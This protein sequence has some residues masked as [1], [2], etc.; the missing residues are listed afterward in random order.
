MSGSDSPLASKPHPS[1]PSSSN[2]QDQQKRS[3]QKD[4]GWSFVKP[5]KGCYHKCASST[6]PTIPQARSGPL[7]SAKD[8]TDEYH[9]LRQDFC[10]NPCHQSIKKLITG[11]AD[12]SCPVTEAICLGIG[13]F[14]PADGGWEAKRRTYIQLFA[15]EAI[16]EELEIITNSKIKC[17]F[18]EPL[19][20]EAD[21]TF[22][23]SLGHR[24]V[25]APLAS[26]AVTSDTLLYGIHLYRNLY[27]EALRSHL[28]AMF[29]GTGWATWD[30]ITVLSIEDLHGLRTMDETYPSGGVQY[31]SLG[32]HKWCAPSIAKY[33]TSH[34]LHN[35]DTQHG[36]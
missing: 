11:S 33:S 21:A 24:V 17:T 7:R 14:D 26:E 16:I 25:E 9:R 10:S 28:P 4:Q 27:A 15:L 23:R 6:P 3:Q 18:Q 22:L 32:K 29:V 34:E 30:G 13:T 35:Q 36:K 31:A 5:R 20:T 19:F 2:S 1:Q 12:S 8:I